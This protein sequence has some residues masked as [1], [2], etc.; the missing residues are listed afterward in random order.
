MICRV[1]YPRTHHLPWSPGRSSDDVVMTSC[2]Q[3]EGKRVI[4]SVKMDGESCVRGDVLIETTDGSMTIAE[5]VEERLEVQ[6]LSYNESTGEIEPQPV[7]G[8]NVASETYEWYEIETADDQ[9]VHLTGEH[10][11]FLPLLGVYRKVCELQD[12]DVVLLCDK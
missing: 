7:I 5:I 8:W 6:V 1:K 2:E 11:V 12:G 10:R 9:V 4:V 3:F